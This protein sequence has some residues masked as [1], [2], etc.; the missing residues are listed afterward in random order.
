MAN[1]EAGSVENKEEVCGTK[2][3]GAQHLFIMFDNQEV[4]LD[5]G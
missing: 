2:D 4:F 5:R 3:A 1:T